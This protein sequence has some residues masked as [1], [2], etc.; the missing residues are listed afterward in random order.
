[1]RILAIDAAETDPRVVYGDAGGRPVIVR[2]SDT[3]VP[4]LFPLAEERSREEDMRIW[5][6]VHQ[7]VRGWL[8]ELRRRFPD[9]LEPAAEETFW[10]IGLPDNWCR[11]Y[12]DLHELTGSFQA[13]GFSHPVLVP[14]T[15]ALL[16]GAERLYGLLS[17]LKADEALLT[18]EWNAGLLRASWRRKDRLLCAGAW[19]VAEET[20]QADTALAAIKTMGCAAC[21]KPAVPIL[22]SGTEAYRPQTL[23]R[24]YARWPGAE[25]YGAAAPDA[26]LA[27]ELWRMAPDEIPPV[28]L[29]RKIEEIILSEADGRS[30]LQPMLSGLYAAAGQELKSLAAGAMVDLARDGVRSWIDQGT[31]NTIFDGVISAFQAWCRDML[32]GRFDGKMEAGKQDVCDEV[33]RVTGAYMRRRGWPDTLLCITPGQLQ[34]HAH[35]WRLPT[36]EACTEFVRCDLQAAFNQL[37]DLVLKMLRKYASLEGA[38]AQVRAAKASLE[39]NVL[40]WMDE[41]LVR[42]QF[43]TS[44]V[45]ALAI[46]MGAR[47]PGLADRW[48]W[49]E[50]YIGN[51]GDEEL[52]MDAEWF[53]DLAETYADR[54]VEPDTAAFFPKPAADGPTAGG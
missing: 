13:A 9:A 47:R 33:N 39:K 12:G 5:D 42:V 29:R 32:P 16:A 51:D 24:V 7:P 2:L 1:M 27:E 30:A 22:L 43:V 25:I 11:V 17:G 36:P 10:I 41:P 46:A 3:S 34:Y 45:E 8:E 37:P 28:Y 35:Q 21:V 53:S 4:A 44:M 54:F 23:E 40:A 26:C 14:R 15:R 19:L 18:L 52:E 6:V 49:G 50:A 31:P 38:W 48:G 20:D